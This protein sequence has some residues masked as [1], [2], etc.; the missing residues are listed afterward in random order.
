M[1]QGQAGHLLGVDARAG[2]VGEPGVED[3]ADALVGQVPGQVPDLLR[4]Q[5][6]ARG[7]HQGL[8]PV[9][10]A[11]GHDPL[12]AGRLPG[13]QHVLGHRHPGQ[14]VRQD[15]G[16]RRRVDRHRVE[17]RGRVLLQ[18]LEHLHDPRH[19][20]DHQGPGHRLAGQPAAGQSAPHQAAPRQQQE[21]AQ[22]Q[23]DHHVAAGHRHVQHVGQDRQGAEEH[24][25]GGDHLPVLLHG[26]ADQAHVAGAPQ[27]QPAPPG[28]AEHGAHQPVGHGEPAEL[29]GLLVEAEAQQLRQHERGGQCRRVHLAQTSDVSFPPGGRS[30]GHVLLEHV[31]HSPRVCG[32][33]NTPPTPPGVVPA[34]ID[35]FTSAHRCKQVLNRGQSRGLDAP[36]SLLA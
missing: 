36:P 1:D 26:V 18:G 30:H 33:R 22:R 6:R 9:G 10:A 15:P 13:R 17:A 16:R 32:G 3:Q 8:D 23:G 34:P 29:Q 11:R 27:F 20:P 5:R 19:A 7:H 2:D 31:G 4:A 24:Q 12:H 14:V 35:D 28:G 21:R 25:R